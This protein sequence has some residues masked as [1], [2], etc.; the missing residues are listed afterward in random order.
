M[1]NQKLRIL[2]TV[3]AYPGISRRDGERVGVAGVDVE[4]PGWIRLFPVPCRDMPSDRRF[5]KFDVI[6]LQATK[7]SDPRPESH[8]PNADTITV[9]DHI[10][11]RRG[12]ERRRFIDPLICP[13]MCAIRREQ[14]ANGTSLGAFRPAGPPELVIVE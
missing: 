3:K 5:R 7:S 13:S 14:S 2:V 9:V 8:E 11:S 6:D 4:R 10:P 12:D 1:G